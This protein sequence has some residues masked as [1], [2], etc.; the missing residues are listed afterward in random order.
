MWLQEESNLTLR[1]CRQPATA[2]EDPVRLSG[3]WVSASLRVA[4]HFQA[5]QLGP[6][7]LHP[8]SLRGAWP[9]CTVPQRQ[10]TG[11]EVWGQTHCPGD[12]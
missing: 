6:Q 11:T 7:T 5:E 3:L 10:P 8:L 2:K 4:P 12:P 9:R 1:G